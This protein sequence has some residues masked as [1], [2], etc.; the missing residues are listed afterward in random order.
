MALSHYAFPELVIQ[1]QLRLD[2]MAETTLLDKVL[3]STEAVEMRAQMRQAAVKYLDSLLASEASMAS[4]LGYVNKRREAEARK[5]VLYL[6]SIGALERGFVLFVRDWLNC[7]DHCAAWVGA[8]IGKIGRTGVGEVE[9][10]RDAERL[11]EASDEFRERFVRGG[12]R[13]EL[14]YTLSLTLINVHQRY[15]VVAMMLRGVDFSDGEGG[16]VV[17]TM[18][19]HFA[20]TCTALV[21]MLSGALKLTERIPGA[22][23]KFTNRERDELSGMVSRLDKLLSAM[24]IAGVLENRRTE[25]V[26]RLIWQDLTRFFTDRIAHVAMQ[27]ATV[28]ITARATPTLDHKDVVWLVGLLW[29]WHQLARRYN[30]AG[31]FFDRW[32]D[33][34]M[35]DL[36]I[37]IER[38]ARMEEGESLIERMNH[39]I[40]L[41]EYLTIFDRRVMQFLSVSSVNLA[42]MVTMILERPGTLSPEEQALVD[43]F[44]AMA[45]TELARNKNWRSPE[46]MDLIELADTRNAL[47]APPPRSV[48]QAVRQGAS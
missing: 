35:E 33:Q 9:L 22:S 14:P 37:A 41:N 24:V 4:F 12:T 2:Q 30:Q 44:L 42:R 17:E 5:R 47:L 6:G 36:K 7:A 40:R 10:E 39:L 1:I 19:V 23:I 18:L 16:L 11:M 26:F 28:G 34:M 15:D 3:R 43:D 31:I 48:K 45:R 25:P 32:R 38:A 13:S 21:E 20:T 29:S 27:R 46:L 8:Q